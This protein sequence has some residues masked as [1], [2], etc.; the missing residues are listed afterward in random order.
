[1]LHSTYTTKREECIVV[2]YLV[3]ISAGETC[4]DG[5]LGGDTP[6]GAAGATRPLPGHL[7]R[8]KPT[9]PVKTSDRLQKIIPKRRKLFKP[10]P[11][12]TR[13]VHKA[14]RKE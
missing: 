13:K 4:D 7:I 14:L 10:K 1:M 6:E 2:N 5:G 11:M 3:D 8:L 12:T 9:N